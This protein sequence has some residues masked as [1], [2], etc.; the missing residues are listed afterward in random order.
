[1]TFQEALEVLKQHEVLDFGPVRDGAEQARFKDGGE[2]MLADATVGGR[3]VPELDRVE[4][5][6]RLI[7]AAAARGHHPASLFAVGFASALQMQDESGD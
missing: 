1:M 4:L 5:L 6:A 2:V 3:K 7:T